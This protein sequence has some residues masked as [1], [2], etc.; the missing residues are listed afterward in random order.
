MWDVWLAGVLTAV[1]RVCFLLK[2][3]GARKGSWQ[4]SASWWD[5]DSGKRRAE[6]APSKERRWRGR[7]GV[8]WLPKLGQA[9]LA[10]SLLKA[11]SSAYRALI[12]SSGSK[13]GENPKWEV[14]VMA[15][16]V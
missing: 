16:T 14:E 5:T 12:L 10:S 11:G 15:W 7:G 3:M 4:R 6:Q 1:A 8:L 13:R 2:R 9:E